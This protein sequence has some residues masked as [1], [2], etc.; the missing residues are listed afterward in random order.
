MSDTVDNVLNVVSEA[1]ASGADEPAEDVVVS[2]ET[3]LVEEAPTEEV[4]EPAVEEVVESEPVSETS[5]AEPVSVEEVVQNVQEILTTP[6]NEDLSDKLENIANFV[7][8]NFKIS[9]NNFKDSSLEGIFNEIVYWLHSDCKF[10]L[11]SE[12]TDT[13]EDKINKVGN[14]LKLN[15]NFNF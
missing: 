10:K 9:I 12:E 3:E 6:V 14:F 11:I 1:A 7:S 5:V 2:E 15:F 13:L 8:N 4:E